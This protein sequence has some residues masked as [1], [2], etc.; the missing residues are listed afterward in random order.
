MANVV[1][2]PHARV[3]RIFFTPLKGTSLVEVDEANLGPTGIKNDRR[4]LVIDANAGNRF[5]AQRGGSRSQGI[6]VPQICTI[7]P[8]VEDGQLVLAGPRMKSF[9]VPRV[10]EVPYEELV[11]VRIWDEECFA[12]PVDPEADNWINTYLSRYRPGGNY[13]IVQMPAQSTRRRRGLPTSFVDASHVLVISQA[14]F[15]E[16]NRRLKLKGHLPL[17]W[18]RLRPNL[19][20]DGC[21]EHAEDVPEFLQ[22][23]GATFLGG[24]LCAR[25][26]ATTIVQST[27][28]S[29]GKEPLVE[30]AKYRQVIPGSK[31]VAFGRNLTWLSGDVIK[32]G[33]PVTFNP[34][35]RV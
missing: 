6:A 8:R 31:E 22:I 13:R 25:C 12:E 27:G 28:K 21:A 29:G 10:E 14:S 15:D 18:D 23:G 4:W 11:P 17:G 35:P 32:R 34:G 24:T 20:I 30:L 16:L 19:V 3:T 7:T 26:G 33:D 9:K 2:L 5:V 1:A